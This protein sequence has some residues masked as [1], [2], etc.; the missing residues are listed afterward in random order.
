M[1]L[2]WSID[3]N[4][5]QVDVYAFLGNYNVQLRKYTAYITYLVQGLPVCFIGKNQ[6]G[7]ERHMAKSP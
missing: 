6:T 7:H 1:D 5:A 3:V 4:S 2:V